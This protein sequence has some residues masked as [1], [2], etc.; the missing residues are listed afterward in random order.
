MTKGTRNLRRSIGSGFVLGLSDRRVGECGIAPTTAD[1]S[2]G[3]FGA[4]P[5][6]LPAVSAFSSQCRCT[7]RFILV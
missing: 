3:A 5:T 6:T 7:I 2:P 1:S 4:G